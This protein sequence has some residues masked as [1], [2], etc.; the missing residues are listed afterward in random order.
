L[1]LIIIYIKKENLNIFAY[2]P[3]SK[4][5]GGQPAAETRASGNQRSLGGP[6]AFVLF[7]LLKHLRGRWKGQRPILSPHHA[8]P[9]HA[10][11][12]TSPVY[13]IHYPPIAFLQLSL[14]ESPSYLHL[15]KLPETLLVSKF[16]PAVDLIYI[17]V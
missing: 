10:H 8:M 2:V 4:N 5:N 15:W 3:T 1:S 11:T 7:W 14:V 9:C 6:L 12:I 17:A 13:K 16:G